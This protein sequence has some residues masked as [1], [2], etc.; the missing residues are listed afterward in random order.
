MYIYVYAYAHAHRSGLVMKGD[1]LHRLDYRTVAELT[2]HSV[3]PMLYGMHGSSVVLGLIKVCIH[4]C[5]HACIHTS[6]VVWHAWL[7]CGAGPDRGMYTCIHTYIHTSD[8]VWHAWLQCG[9]GPDQGM[10]TYIHTYV[11]WMFWGG[12]CLLFWTDQDVYAYM[13]ACACACV[14]VSI[15]TCMHACMH[16]VQVL[17][18]CTCTFAFATD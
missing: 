12:L 13:R 5:M 10:Y 16:T 17:F 11:S 4:T 3:R 7:Q 8:V 18:S 14:P 6:D 15:Y 1:L 9:A 2:I